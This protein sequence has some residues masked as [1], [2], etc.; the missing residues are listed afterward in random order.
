MLHAAALASLENDNSTPFDDTGWTY[1]NTTG[2][3]DV[4]VQ[5]DSRNFKEHNYTAEGLA[6][7]SAFAIKIVGQST[8]TSIIPVVSNLRAIALAT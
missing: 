6:E 8:S 7:F 1:F 2:A 4:A 3:P 5:T